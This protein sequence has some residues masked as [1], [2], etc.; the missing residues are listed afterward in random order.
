MLVQQQGTKKAVFKKVE[1]I[2]PV[3]KSGGGSS[4]MP[5]LAGCFAKLSETQ[6]SFSRAALLCSAK[7][8]TSQPKI[9]A[10]A[11]AITSAFQRRKKK[12]RRAL[13]LLRRCPHT[14][15]HCYWSELSPTATLTCKDGQGTQTSFR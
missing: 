8:S 15:T 1:A 4:G 13:S 2:F 14:L 11:Q 10:Q 9:A 6:G 3:L 12:R 5:G 7:E